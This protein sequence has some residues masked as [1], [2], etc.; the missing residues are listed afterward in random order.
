MSEDSKAWQQR[1]ELLLGK[2]KTDRL[3]QAHVTIL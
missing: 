3:R 2:D 1:T